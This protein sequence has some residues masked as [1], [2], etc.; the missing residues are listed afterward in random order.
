MFGDRPHGR[1][2]FIVQVIITLTA[3]FV[4]ILTRGLD[5]FTV[6]MII[7]IFI[8]WFFSIKSKRSSRRLRE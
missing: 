2:D 3:V 6:L 4:I 7:V 1:S 5:I 8:A